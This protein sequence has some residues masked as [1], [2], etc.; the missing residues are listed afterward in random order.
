M[1]STAR[2]PWGCVEAFALAC[3]LLSPFGVKRSFHHG[4]VAS[5]F[6]LPV[7]MELKPCA[8]TRGKIAGQLRQQRGTP[9]KSDRRTTLPISGQSFLYFARLIAKGPAKIHALMLSALC[10]TSSTAR[11]PFSSLAKPTIRR[12]V[13][14]SRIMQASNNEEPIRYPVPPFTEETAKQKVKAAQVGR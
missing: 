1:C 12:F 13:S 11:S 10:R 8:M 2:F 5:S 9:S 3:S 4:A 7:W 6:Q 14:S